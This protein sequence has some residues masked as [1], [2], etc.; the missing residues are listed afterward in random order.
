MCPSS[1]IYTLN[2]KG[3]EEHHFKQFFDDNFLISI[4]TDDTC[5]MDCNLT[6]ELEMTVKTFKLDR[7]QVKKLLLGSV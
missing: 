6:S 3:M 2:L 4:C 7:D 5:V 1:N